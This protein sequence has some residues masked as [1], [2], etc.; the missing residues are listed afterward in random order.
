MVVKTIRRCFL[1]PHGSL[2]NCSSR[3]FSFG[4]SNANYCERRSCGSVHMFKQIIEMKVFVCSAVSLQ[5]AQDSNLAGTKFL[6][7]GVGCTSNAPAAQCGH[8]SFFGRATLRRMTLVVSVSTP[9]VLDAIFNDAKCKLVWRNA[10]DLEK[11]FIAHVSVDQ[12]GS[13]WLVRRF[14]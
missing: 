2:Y 6:T 4:I 14:R 7:W 1:F 11:T 8:P 3:F 13:I 12:F 10:N 9:F 5:I